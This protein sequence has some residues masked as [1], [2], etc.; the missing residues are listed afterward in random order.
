MSWGLV[1]VAG[2]TIVGS[3]VGSKSSKDASKASSKASAEASAI[4]REMAEQARKD[5]TKLFSQAREDSQRGF[6][7]ALDVFSQSLPAQAQAFQGGNI[8]AQE[9]LIAGLPLFQNA[10]LGGN[11]DFSQLQPTQVQ[12]PDLGF[13]QQQLPSTIQAQEDATLNSGLGPYTPNNPEFNGLMGPFQIA[14]TTQDTGGFFGNLLNPAPPPPNAFD[15][16]IGAGGGFTGPLGMQMRQ[17]G[18]FGMGPSA[19]IIAQAQQAAQRQQIQPPQPT[20][21]G[22]GDQFIPRQNFLSGG[23]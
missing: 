17:A 1:A 9:Q 18:G 2:A 6:Q 22:Q 10:I 16:F 5:S 15:N 21:I 12:T 7:G 13:F 23:F 20:N 3:V 11:V 4:T 8:G 19:N 14:P